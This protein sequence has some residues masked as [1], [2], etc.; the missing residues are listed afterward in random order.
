MHQN[1]YNNLLNLFVMFWIDGVNIMKNK[2]SY[3]AFRRLYLNLLFTILLAYSEIFSL[4]NHVP[5][6]T[7]IDFLNYNLLNENLYSSRYHDIFD[8]PNMKFK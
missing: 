8:N 1:S 6:V 7:D 3:L 5:L 2:I 4:K